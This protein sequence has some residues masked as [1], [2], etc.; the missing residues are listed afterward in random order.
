M[1]KVQHNTVFYADKSRVHL[2]SH[3]SKSLLDELKF[4][5]MYSFRDVF[6]HESLFLK[7]N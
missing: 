2:H 4:Q 6:T 5:S 7:V 1:F 3:W